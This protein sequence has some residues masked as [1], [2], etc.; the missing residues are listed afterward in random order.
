M[1]QD[2]PSDSDWYPPAKK[3]RGVKRKSSVPTRIIKQSQLVPSDE[4]LEQ[5][6]LQADTSSV[7]SQEAASLDGES[8]GGGRRTPTRRGKDHRWKT[9]LPW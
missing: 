3:A 7:N 2:D 6:S 5:D 4:E 9:V 1:G 8:G